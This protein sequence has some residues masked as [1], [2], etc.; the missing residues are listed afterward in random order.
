MVELDGE[1]EA[2]AVVRLEARDLVAVAHFHRSLDADE[3]LG[4]GLLDDA[5]GLQQ[6]HERAGRAVHDRHFGR[7]QV[8]IGVVDAQAGQRRHQVFDGHA[9]WRRRRD[10]PVHR[11]V[12]LTSSASAGISTTGSRS[13]RRNTMPLSTGGRTQGEVDLFAAVQSHA[14]GADHVL[15]GAL[16]HGVDAGPEVVAGAETSRD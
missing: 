2:E 10:R 3:A 4:R 15:E 8:D 12:S 16:L 14:G 13:T 6:E 9:P 5:G 1:A 7:G 11:V